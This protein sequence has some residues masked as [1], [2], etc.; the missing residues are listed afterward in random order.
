[1]GN[2]GGPAQSNEGI[3]RVTARFEQT[4]VAVLRESWDAK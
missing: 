1:M 2:I 4:L 3:Q